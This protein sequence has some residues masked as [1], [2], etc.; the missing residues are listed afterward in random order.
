[1]FFL[2]VCSVGHYVVYMDICC[3]G[4]EVCDRVYLCVSSIFMACDCDF[5]DCDFSYIFYSLI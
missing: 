4:Y 1:M 5:I 2:R 3:D